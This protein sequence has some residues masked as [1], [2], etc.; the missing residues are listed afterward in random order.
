MAQIIKRIDLKP[1]AP[2]VLDFETIIKVI[3]SQQLSGK[4]ADTIFRRVLQ[5][6]NGKI[7]IKSF[8]KLTDQQLRMC[9]ISS[10]KISF[11]R[12]AEF[13]LTTDT[14]FFERIKYLDSDQVY[15]EFRKI[16]GIGEWSASILAL[17]YL[18]HPDVF[19]SGDATLNK[20]INQLYGLDQ[21]KKFVEVWS[22]YRSIA[23]LCLWRWVDMGRPSL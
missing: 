20:A 7:D 9:G 12:D 15:I 11:M 2:R 23:A 14:E 19:P 16:K 5:L 6:S 10:T 4:A 13:K 3:I 18:Q 17:F 22:P 21:T 1:L 8:T